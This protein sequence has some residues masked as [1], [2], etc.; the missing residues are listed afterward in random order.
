MIIEHI[1]NGD[2]KPVSKEFDLSNSFRGN[3]K[4]INDV[5]AKWAGI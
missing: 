2:A 4:I 3:K 1:K 5:P